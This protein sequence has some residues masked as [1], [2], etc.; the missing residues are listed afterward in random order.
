VRTAYRSPGQ[1]TGFIVGGP[2][3]AAVMVLFA[4]LS[5][6]DPGLVAFCAAGAAG[7]VWVGLRLA[8]CGVYPE[9]GGIRVLN[10]VRT[11]H[12]RWDG[13]ASFHRSPYGA[14][15][16][17][18]VHGPS[19]RIFGI[20]QRAIDAARKKGD[21]PEATLIDEL[22]ALLAQQQQRSRD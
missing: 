3:V 10:P 21:T 17:K 2:F 6:D 13:I 4:A 12:L 22:N 11:V 14:C 7:G 9:P 18:R 5:L 15:L 8:A 19:V 20:Q 1:R 16:V